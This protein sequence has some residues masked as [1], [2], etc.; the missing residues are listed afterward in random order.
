MGTLAAGVDDG[1]LMAV[2][3]FNEQALREFIREEL[4]RSRLAMLVRQGQGVEVP[5]TLVNGWTTQA[6]YGA[7]VVYRIGRL[8]I[9][10][11]VL[12]SAAATNSLCMTLPAGARPATVWGSPVNY[13][14]GGRG[15]GSA[16]VYPDGSL[17]VLGNAD[18]LVAVSDWLI[19]LVFVAAKV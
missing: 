11:A 1:V 7:P 12:N 2:A 4:D 10:T 14:A 19:N 13:Y 18:G 3:D 9:V 8:V 15:M 6:T 16:F 17:R 5:V